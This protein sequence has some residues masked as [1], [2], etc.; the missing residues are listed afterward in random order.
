MTDLMAVITFTINFER[1]SSLMGGDLH[2]VWV[3]G[4][5]I[6]QGVVKMNLLRDEKTNQVLGRYFLLFIKL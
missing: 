1:F 2:K 5:G 4:V 6:F 3:V